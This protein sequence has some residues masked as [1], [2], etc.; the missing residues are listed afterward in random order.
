MNSQTGMNEEHNL[1]IPSDQMLY[2]CV[3]IRNCEQLAMSQLGL[4]E[5]ELMQRAGQGAFDYFLKCYPR[6]SSVAVFCGAGNNAGD[7]Y[8][9]ACLAKQFGLKVQVYYTKAP[10]EL[11]P[12]AAQAASKA[13]AENVSCFCF[14]ESIELDVDV[15]V[16]ALLGIGLKGEVQGEIAL[17]VNMINDSQLPI[18]SLDIPTG[19]NADSGQVYNCCVRAEHTVSFIARKAGLYTLDGPDY[20]GQIHCVDLDLAKVIEQ[21]PPF[22]YQ[23]SKITADV[24]LPPR[25]KNTHKGN[26]GH[27]LIIGGGRGMPGAAALSAKAALRS[28]A[29]SVTVAT[30]KEHVTAILPACPESMVCGIESEKELQVLLTRATICVLGPGL[31]EDQWS[32]NLFHA[33]MATQIP[34]VIDASAIRLLAE[35]SQYDDNW[36]LTPHPG[37]AASLLSVST[38][39]VQSNRFD[40][41]QRIQDQYGGVVILKGAGSIIRTAAGQ[42]YVCTAGN[43]GMAT[44]G[45]GDILSGIIAGLLAQGYSLSDAA[46][47]AVWL[48]A[49]AGDMVAHYHGQRGLIASDLLVV[50]P[51]IINGLV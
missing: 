6:A 49:H 12:A 26:Y 20:S 27:V 40:A 35:Q 19:L 14:E 17:A 51:D 30:L 4:H 21:T 38:A 33:A 34:M 28:G 13:V 39:E 8:V 2:R 11:P 45:M 23:L 3:E 41:A 36:I 48:H 46:K 29:G 32:R 43:P 37:E 44:A 25:R 7:G 9:F 16:D 5:N 31:G 47:T 10:E 50:I 24:P 18:M 15:I 42:N 1:L 22:A